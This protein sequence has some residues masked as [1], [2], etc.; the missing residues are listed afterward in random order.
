MA[1]QTSFR[2]IHLCQTEFR[3]ASRINVTSIENK[4]VKSSFS[5]SRMKFQK[6]F[7]LA[8]LKR[9]PSSTSFPLDVTC[10]RAT[11]HAAIKRVPFHSHRG[12]PLIA[13]AFIV[14]DL[15]PLVPTLE[16]SDPRA[17]T[18]IPESLCNVCSAIV[19]SNC[20]RTVGG[21][22]GELEWYLQLEREY[23]A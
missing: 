18:K 1:A 6:A 22:G 17:K 15:A 16:N 8:P 7:L 19:Y 5:R 10:Q 23:R 3:S 14:T 4:L 2:Q 12:P 13:Y 20:R 21:R 11:A 9:D